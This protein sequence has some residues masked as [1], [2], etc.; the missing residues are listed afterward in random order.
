MSWSHTCAQGQPWGI[1]SQISS[2]NEDPLATMTFAGLDAPSLHR[3]P[4][5]LRQWSEVPW[6]AIGAGVLLARGSTRDSCED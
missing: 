3:S 2:A 4:F 1:G 6:P 5:G